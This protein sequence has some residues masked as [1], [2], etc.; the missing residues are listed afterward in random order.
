MEFQKEKKKKKKKR[1]FGQ[2]LTQYYG[3]QAI[4]KIYVFAWMRTWKP[5][6]IIREDI[7]IVL[8]ALKKNV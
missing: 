2:I 8:L 6:N 4:F 1:G 5:Q 3:N 7:L